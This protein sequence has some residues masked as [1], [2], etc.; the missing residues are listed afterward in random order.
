MKENGLFLFSLI[1]IVFLFQFE[2]PYVVYTPGGA[3][4]LSDRVK[5]ED[6]YE[7]NGS[8]SMAYV[9]MIKGNIPFVLLLSLIHISEPTRL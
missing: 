6:G 4:D 1:A 8:L 7:S 5:V 3:I 9:S 2:L